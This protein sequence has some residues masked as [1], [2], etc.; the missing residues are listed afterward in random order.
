M[1][2]IDSYLA[3]MGVS[4]PRIR[5]RLEA[6]VPFADR[7]AVASGSGGGAA[8]QAIEPLNAAGR[9]AM[10]A[11]AEA[12]VAGGMPG[13]V[14]DDGAPVVLICCDAN[15]ELGGLEA[16]AA[17]LEL[18]AFALRLPEA[19]AELEEAPADVAELAVQALKAAKKAVPPGR[20]LILA[21]VGHGA[22]L[23]HELAIQLSS[24]SAPE[25]VQALALLEPLHAPRRPALLLTWLTAEARREACAV[26]AALYPAVAAA[27]GAAAPGPDAFAARLASL[28][29]HDAQL[30]YV[31]SFKPA[32]VSANAWFGIAWGAQ[33]SVFQLRLYMHHAGFDPKS[34]WLIIA[35][36]ESTV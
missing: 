22:L 19:V 8:R 4:D 15:G 17:S 28:A 26:V 11:A 21:G 23:A 10:A 33:C 12:A 5:A 35:A 32:E 14:D 13:R 3:K 20:A 16:V 9:H 30:N 25:A 18:P 24:S 7:D 34:R 1:Q 6:G 31:A 36:V 2:D 27:A 29:G